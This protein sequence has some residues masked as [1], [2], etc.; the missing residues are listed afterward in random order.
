MEDYA[1]ILFWI[2]VIVVWSV[3]S[4][5]VKTINNSKK[6][7]EFKP[8]IDSYEQSKR[9]F[10]RWKDDIA[11]KLKEKEIKLEERYESLVNAHEKKVEKDRE[12]WKIKAAAWNEKIKKIKTKLIKSL[13]KNP[14]AFRGWL[15]H[16]QIILRLKI[17]K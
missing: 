9:D 4:W 1:F 8:K 5:V 11:L 17:E 14:W 13:G 12:N 10:K 6:Y 7:K 15:K 2:G 3:I 16:M